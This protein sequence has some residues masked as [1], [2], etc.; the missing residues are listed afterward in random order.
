MLIGARLGPCVIE[1]LV[2]RGG[3]GA[4]YKARH[5]ALD[6]VVAVKVLAAA[7]EASQ[8]ATLAEARAA[9]K[10]DD[11]RI[12]AIHEVGEADGRPYIV[13]QWIE[14]ESLEARVLRAGPLTPEQALAV[15]KETLAA[16]AVAHEA[17]VVHR[18][19]KPGNILLPAKGG[20]KLA[21]FGLALHV[22]GG[23]AEDAAGTAL[24]MAPEQGYGQAA[25][26]RADL[27]A[28]GGTWL[29]ALSGQ[30]PFG[31]NDG[32]ALLRHRDEAPPDAA[33]LRPGVSRRYAALIA[34]LLS[35]KPEERPSSAAAALKE[36]SEYGFLLEIA[37]PLGDGSMRLLAPAPQPASPPR[38]GRAPAVPNAWSPPGLPPPPPPAPPAAR[39]SRG[40]FAA[41]LLVFIMAA[42]GGLLLKAG[43]EDWVAC[44]VALGAAVTAL[45]LGERLQP[46]RKPA[47]VAAWSLAVFCAGRYA[48]LT[49]SSVE[50]MALSGLGGA[51]G[52]AA[53]YLGLWGQDKD[54]AMWARLLAPAGTLMLAAAAVT[55]G[56][57]E[58]Q[59]WGDALTQR[60]AASHAA[61]VA[62]GGPWRWLGIVVLAGALVIAGRLKKNSER[63]PEP[64]D[65]KLN[66][67]R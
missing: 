23:G 44:C 47:G 18:D 59:A 10:L 40:A 36:C 38:G 4:V 48:G 3:M 6:R 41:I 52:A 56:A 45:T 43:P 1:A 30:P 17:G 50:A 57:P 65:R 8:A 62:S 16:L 58:P 14:G 15:M 53:V 31:R 32:E 25:D 37:A 67:N 34:R 60:G 29:Y 39:G 26:A 35:K 66:W 24:F 21:D 42:L 28:V 55:W 2:G 64:R 20:V 54:E 22:G 19:I 49:L 7:G 11:P 9:A 46:W 12:V 5:L 61:F 51:C 27:Y 13:M 63:G 33:T